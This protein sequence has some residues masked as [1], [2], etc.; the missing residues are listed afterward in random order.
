MSRWNLSKEVSDEWKVKVEEHIKK[1]QECDLEEENPYD[2]ELDLSGTSLNPSTLKYLLES[3]GWNEDDWDTNGWEWD[4]WAY[5]SK[6][7]CKRICMSGC[8]MTFSLY[9]RGEEE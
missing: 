5:Y 4:F 2:V 7:G 9:L 6:S 3:L 1:I 8:G